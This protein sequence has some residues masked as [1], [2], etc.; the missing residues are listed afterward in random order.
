M[1]P[2]SASVAASQ[3]G[4]RLGKRAG[5]QQ[6]SGTTPAPG[7]AHDF[8]WPRHNKARQHVHEAFARI[9]AVYRKDFPRDEWAA[10]G[11]TPRENRR[12]VLVQVGGA[13]DVDTLNQ[14]TPEQLESALERVREH[15]GI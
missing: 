10:D 7:T 1:R 13:P 8:D 15:F 9:S 4:L 14:M 3:E 2:L 6:Q 5:A 11:D 12:K